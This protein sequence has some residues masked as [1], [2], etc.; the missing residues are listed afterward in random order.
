MFKQINRKIWLLNTSLVVLF[1]VGLASVNASFLSGTI[2]AQLNELCLKHESLAFCSPLKSWLSSLSSDEQSKIPSPLTDP[3]NLA[4]VLATNSISPRF[5]FTVNVES[6]FRENARFNK[7]VDIKGTLTAPNLF[8]SVVAGNGIAVSGAKVNPVI[9]STGVLSL[10]GQTG[11]VSFTGSGIDIVGTTFTNTGVTSFQG[12]TGAVTLTNGSGIAISGTTI[13]NSGVLSLQGQTGSIT[14]TPG[15]GIA[16]SGTTI[17][18]Q[19]P[20]S[21]QNIFKTITVGNTSFSASGNTDTLT[22]ASGSGVILTSDTMN[23]IVSTGINLTSSGNAGVASSSSGLE[24]SSAG[25]TL[26]KGCANNQILKWNTTTS[27]WECKVDSGGLGTAGVINVENNETPVGTDV[28]TMDFSTDF[29]LTASPSNEANISIADDILSFTEFSDTLSLDASTDFLADNAEV[30]SLTN[31]GTGNSFLVNDVA[32]DS[33]PFVIDAGGNVG[34][35]TTSPLTSLQIGAETN[36]G[37]NTSKFLISDTTV[38]GAS[39]LFTDFNNDAASIGINRTDDYFTLASEDSSNGIKFRVNAPWGTNPLIQGGTEAMVI[40]SN[41]RVGIG[42]TTP[43][44]LLDISGT[45][46]ISGAL[47]LYTTP[48]I[49]STANQTLTLGGDTTGNIALADL[50]LFNA[51]ATIASGQ[52]LTLAGL[53]ANNNQVLYAANTTGVVTSANTA[54]QN[55]CLVSGA[56]APT[57]QSCALGAGTNFWNSSNGALYPGNSTVDLLVGGTATASAKFGFLNVAGGTPTASISANSSNNAAYLTGDGTLATTNRQTFTIGN[58]SAYNTTGNILLNPNG[59]G[60]VGIGTTTPDSKLSVSDSY[61]GFSDNIGNLRIFTTDA[62]AIDKGGTLAFGGNADATR[63]FTMLGGFKESSTGSDFAGYFALGTRPSG[64]STTERLRVTSTGNLGINTTS[65]LATLDVRG[66]SATT[67]AASISANS[68]FAS[69]IVDNR[70]SG[71]LFTASKS[72]ARKFV[73]NPDG[74]LGLAGSATLSNRYITAPNFE[75]VDNGDIYGQSLRNYSTVNNALVNTAS[76]G[77]TISRNIA[78]SNVALIVQQVNSSSTGDIL[79]VKNNSATVFNVLQNGN[80]QINNLNGQNGVIYGTQTTGLLAQA[81]TATQNLCLVSGASAPTWQSC[82]LGAGTNFWNSSNGAL[83]PGNSTL[84]LLVGGTATTSAKFGFLNVAGGTPTASISANSGNNAAYLTGNGTLATANRGTLTIGNS[85][86]FNTTGD[87]LINPS[88]VGWVGIGGNASPA[89]ALAVRGDIRADGNIQTSNL[90]L[91]TTGQGFYGFGTGTGGTG[92]TLALSSGNGTSG[93]TGTSFDLSASG[94]DNSEGIIYYNGY[95]W[96][97]DDIDGEVYKYNTDGTYTNSSFDTVASGNDNPKGI[98]YYNGY[99]W[100]PD[101]TDDAVYKYNTDGTYTGTSFDTA[102]SGNADPESITY[103]NG[104]FWIADDGDDEVYKY[105]TDGTYTGTSFDTNAIGSDDPE[106]ITYYNGYFWIPDDGDDEVYK[107]NTDGTYTGTSFDTTASGNGDPDGITFY[108]GFFWISDDAD[109]EVYKYNFDAYTGGTIAFST[110]GSERM[111]INSSGNIGIG[112]TTPTALLDVNGTASISGALKLYGTP[113]IQSTANQTLTLGGDTTGNITLSPLNNTGGVG[114]NRAAQYALDINRANPSTAAFSSFSHLGIR[115]SDSTT[116]NFT[117]LSF[118]GSGAITSG[119]ASKNIDQSNAYAQL[120]FYT[121]GTSGFNNRMTILSNGQL[122]VGEGSPISQLHVSRP[123][124]FGTT[125]KSLAIFDQIENQDIL[126]AS[127]GGITKF[128]ITNGGDLRIAAAQN[129][130]TLTAGTLGIGTTN[131][132][133]LTLGRSGQGIT[134]PGFTGQNAVLYGT[135]TTGVLAQATTASQNLC[136]V[137]GASAPTW[138]S[139]ALGAGTNW[140]DS[141]AGA[142]YPNNSTKDLLIGGTATTS[143]KFAVLNMAGG[144]PIASVSSGLNGVGAYL[145]ADGTLATTNRGTLT[146]GNSS[147]YNTTGNILL[148]PNGTGNVGIGVT[149]PTSPLTVKGN[150]AVT[151]SGLEVYNGKTYLYNGST[152]ATL[153]Q[154]ST[155]VLDVFSTTGSDDSLIRW[156]PTYVDSSSINGRLGYSGAGEISLAASNASLVF[157]TSSSSERMRIDTSGNVGINTTSPLA[158]LDVRGNSGTTPAASISAQSSFAALVVDNK[159]LGDLFTASSSGLN[160]FVIKQNGNVGIGTT[161]PDTKLQVYAPNAFSGTS[162]VA[163]TTNLGNIT[164][165]TT[166]A[167]GT[168]VGAMVSLGGNRASNDPGVFGGIRGAKENSTSGNNNGYLGFYTVQAGVAFAE[169][170]RISSIGNVGIGTTSPLATLD[171]RG[172][173]ATTPISSLSGSTNFATMLVNNNGSGDLFTASKSGATKFTILNNG[174]LQLA[175][176]TNFLSTLASAA[177]SAQTWTLPDATGT[178]CISGQS[179]ASSGVVGFW[180]RNSGALAPTNITDDL[181]LGSTATTSAK[182]GFLN[183]AGGTPTASI[184]ANSGNNAVY[185]T[186]DGS[187]AT[188]NRGTLTLGNSSTHNTTGNILLNPNGAGNVGIGTTNPLARLDVRTTGTAIEN[189]ASFLGDGGGTVDTTITI[190]ANTGGDTGEKYITYRNANTGAN[191]WMAGMND[192]DKFS[193]DYTTAGEIRNTNPLMTLDQSGNLG[194]GTDTILATLDVRGNLATTPATS[195]SANSNFAAMV[196]DNRGLGDIFTASSSGLNRFVIKQNGNIGINTNTPDALLQIAGSTTTLATLLNITDNGSTVFKVDK[197]QITSAAPHQFTAAGDVSIAYDLQFTNQTASFIKSYG[198]LTLEAGEIFE[199]NDLTLRTFNRGNINFDLT[200]EGSSVGINAPLALAT[201][202]VRGNSGTTPVASLSGQSSFAA[203]VVDNKG[204]GDL[205]TASSSGLPRFTVEQSGKL[206]LFSPVTDIANGNT[207]IFVGSSPTVTGS[208][209]G[210]T[211]TN[212]QNYGNSGNGL[213]LQYGGSD[214]S[215]GI[216]LTDDGVAIWGAGD[217]DLFRVINEDNNNIAFSIS[218]T[219]ALFSVANNTTQSFRI[220][221]AASTTFFNADSTNQRIGIGTGTNSLF[222]T[223]DV[224]GT[225]ATTPAASISAQSS[226]ASLIVDNS[227]VGDLFTASKSGKTKFTILNNGNLQLAG[228]TNVLSTLAS[229]ATSTQTWTLPDASG[230]LCISGQDCATSGVVGYWQRISG[231]LAPSNLTD[232][233]L[234][235]A[236]ATTSA[237]FGFLNVAGGTP[238]ASISA[239]SGNNAAYLTGNG[240]LATTNRGTLT[241]GNSSTYNTTGNTLLNPSGVGYVGIGGNASPAAALAVRGDIRADGNIQSNALALGTTGQGFYGFGTATGNA[242]TLSLSSGNGASGY[243]GSSFDTAASGNSGLLDITYYNGYFWTVDVGAD[244]VYKFNTDGTYANKSF[245]TAAS[246][247]GDPFGITYYNG[248]FWI[249]DNVDDE[250]YKYSTDGIYTGTSFDT[251]ASGNG[252]P[253]GITYANGYF[254]ITDFTDSEVYKYSTDGIYTGTSFD[255]AASGNTQIHGITYY[256]GYFWTVDGGADE[257]YKYSTDGVYTGTSFDTAVSG[258]NDPNG[259]TYYNGYFWISENIDDEVY[260]YNFDAYTGGSIALS[261]SGSERMKIDTNGRVIIGTTSAALATLDIRGNNATTPAASISANSHFAS[262]L[263][264]N[265]GTGDLFTASKSG[266]SKFVIANSGNV[267]IGTTSPLAALQVGNNGDT[268]FPKSIFSSDYSSGTPFAN[269]VGNWNNSGAWGLGA[270]TTSGTDNTLRIG[271]VPTSGTYNSWSP[272]QNLRLLLGG[273]TANSAQATFDV[274]SNLG[275]EPAASISAQSSFA[276]MVVDNKGVGDL[277]TAS[278]SGLNRFVIKQNG[279]V[280]IGTTNPQET[281]NVVGSISLEHQS[282][283]AGSLGLTFS[284]PD[285]REESHSIYMNSTDNSL[286]FAGWNGSSWVDRMTMTT[287][288]NIGIGGSAS[289]AA[290]L[291]VRGDIRADGNIEANNLVLGTTGQGFYGFGTATGSAYTLALSS[292]N[293]SSGYTNS[294]FDTA[295]SGN[296]NP[297]GIT[298]YNGYFWITDTSDALVYK[299]NTDGSYANFSFDTAASGNGDPRAMTYYNG[300]FWITDASDAEVYKH[301]TTGTYTGTSFDTAASGNDTPRGI[302]YYNG[303]FWIVDAADEEVYKYNTD[304]TYANFSFDTAPSSNTNPNGITYY[305]GYFWITDATDDEVYKYSTTGTYTGTSF[306]TAAGGSDAPVGMTYYNG[307][308]WIT[309]ITDAR[310]YKYNFDAYTGGNI[311]LS[312]A[313]SERMRIDSTGLVGIGTTTPLWKLHVSNNLVSTASA[314]IENTGAN[315]TAGHTGLIIRMGAANSATNPNANDAFINFMRGDSNRRGQIIGNGATGVTYQTGGADYAEYFAIDESILPINYTEEDK[316]NLFPSGTLVCQ[317]DHGVIPCS[318]TSYPRILGI[319]SDAPAVK[320]G[321]EG[322]DKV[323]VGLL[324][325]VPARVSAANGPIKYGDLLTASN[326]PGIAVKASQAGEVIGRALGNYA[327]SDSSSI[328]SIQIFVSRTWHDPGISISETGDIA[329]TP[330]PASSDGKFK[331]AD[332]TGEIK[333]VG[334]FSDADI[335]NL[336]AGKIDA[337][338]LSINGIDIADLLNQNTSS[339]SAQ[340]V[341]TASDT[342]RFASVEAQ[343]STLSREALAKWDQLSTLDNKISLLE[344]MTKQIASDAAFLNDLLKSPILSTINASQSAGLQ[345]SLE[346]LDVN[347]ATISGDLNVLGR[348][349]LSDLSV[350]GNITN[351][352]LSINGLNDDGFAAINTSAGSLKL[353]SHGLYG[354]D[355]LDG[356]IKI[357]ENGNITTKG[358]ITV[359]KINTDKL[360]IAADTTSSPSATLSTAAGSIIIPAGEISIDVNTSLLTTKSLIF[361][362]P[363]QPIGIGARPKDNNTFS[364]KLQELQPND[365]KV[366]WW[367]IN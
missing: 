66:N 262:L 358:E 123:L 341:L 51:G 227:G 206:A 113:T 128:V 229:A 342:A 105:N 5:I 317:S 131:A 65:P 169:R 34:I 295:A 359:K 231:A 201:F 42:T 27:L 78:D 3:R 187:L 366:N 77:T 356:K 36:L 102:G 218:D 333:R 144:T 125:G 270:A 178:L 99:F 283:V 251:A 107:F 76:T 322:P 137:S 245:D 289:P 337:R 152:P 335:A 9:T 318:T 110:A 258:N 255:T 185:I 197:T 80:V 363:D 207:K 109:D 153:S 211:L 228:T 344:N 189:V 126:T 230:T 328:G 53:T 56:S 18:N 118:H 158:T 349:T 288:G 96:I 286:R 104:Y 257:V 364:I 81:S 52:N 226:F 150:G 326:V 89:A 25:L 287:A 139:C 240:T 98:T 208:L 106:G 84:D 50:T 311:A 274:R 305:N 298:N 86:A 180:Q 91:G 234:L 73:V 47:K 223:L 292:G 151:N 114:I 154:F 157:K 367:I 343:L 23:K 244:E 269:Y 46:S 276:A 284:D 310:V 130:D 304:G 162:V 24:V 340:A 232:D 348:T 313:G 323:I 238:T 2:K 339:S 29:L 38:A 220:L 68:N 115:N 222:S 28:D 8:Q 182:F 354:L 299:Y 55:L 82:A 59:T 163:S 92:H 146:I 334:I 95:F 184:S 346:N 324:G 353:Q 307:Y 26:L 165:F 15:T 200:G 320:G 357:T 32:G 20:G 168:D 210:G 352:L 233:L 179:C 112:T 90:A 195:I 148:N 127:A 237:K 203:L 225:S 193:W 101:E 21:S 281:L 198:P 60:N 54:T 319:I 266:A 204:L 174:N 35:G 315:N 199:S 14:L 275:T 256:N 49:Q 143:A 121:R 215:G 205:F 253:T 155:S 132:T 61:Q 314:M 302:T 224:R 48:T 181:L 183:V 142:L 85:S 277:F 171:I 10:Q 239:N 202:D 362:T 140:W 246:G 175:G 365:V 192:G 7:N 44:A 214:D 330:D 272:T 141:T 264:D 219:E 70:G 306:D 303:Y 72:G 217:E 336:T 360:N 248:Y 117:E 16:I 120:E 285:T 250:V 282:T 290:A 186:G 294:S 325:Q 331:I 58:S 111:R 291:A 300:Y 124:S 167:H 116:N 216:K 159:G 138:Q 39:I 242:H 209:G 173:S 41:G 12:T 160:R 293:G 67:P 43:T 243:T 196:V 316:R 22:F 161:S 271:N 321:E 241:L 93:Y 149:S 296:G 170:M 71:D 252:D 297:T 332:P 247:N 263:V 164:A 301:N 33:T 88:G 194:I 327:S 190:G 273:S 133:T 87:I 97:T 267:G 62:T 176:T 309:D 351:G 69:L 134:L 30:F 172:N 338:K 213:I 119:I 13:T 57:W 136:L 260:K 254:W 6:F 265:T 156:G 1:L 166:D 11:A 347:L 188:T 129:I 312:T 221:D 19:D 122:G 45:A 345:L 4:A 100:I 40:Q 64:G 361:A 108:N 31:V 259:I 212:L 145:T 79:Q 249:A 308:F 103:Y 261:T 17:S 280:G 191:A 279:N 177:T 329:I 268:N 350:T 135:Q 63:T 235:G 94:N 355:I 147:N 83:Y 37:G 75:V 278:S 74:Y 236:T